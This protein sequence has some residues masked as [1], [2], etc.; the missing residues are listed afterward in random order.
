MTDRELLES[1]ARAAG[2]TL[3]WIGDEPSVPYS[4]EEQERRGGING[5]M[6]NPLT[7]DGDAFRLAIQLGIM[8]DHF[9]NALPPSVY[10]YSDRGFSAKEPYGDDPF[11]TTRR[12]VVMAAAVA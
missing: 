9:Q 12:L 5:Y 7:D 4:P 11:A 6:W 8:I 10:V 3:R 2:L 1:A